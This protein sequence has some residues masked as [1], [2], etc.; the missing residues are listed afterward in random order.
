MDTSKLIIF[1]GENADEKWTTATGLMGLK[2]YADAL[3]F[4]HLALEAKLKSLVA[5]KISGY[6]PLIHDLAKLA[7]LADLPLSTEQIADLEEITTFNIRA[8]YDDYKLSFYKKATDEYATRYF[9]IAENL[10]LW[11]KKE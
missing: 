10:L 7:T 1:W 6:P 8:R 5:K 9:T 3:F 2:R 4:C 11:L